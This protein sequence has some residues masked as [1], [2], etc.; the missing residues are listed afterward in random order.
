MVIIANKDSKIKK[1]KQRKTQAKT[2]YASKVNKQLKKKQKITK[3]I[4]TMNVWT[5]YVKQIQEN[6]RKRII[7]TTSKYF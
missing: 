1:A 7:K 3:N 2:K 5:K 4:D 6:K